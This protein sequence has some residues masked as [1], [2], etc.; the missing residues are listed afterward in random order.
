MVLMEPTLTWLLR[1]VCFRLVTLCCALRERW[2]GSDNDVNVR[3]SGE[4][5]SV[6][7]LFLDLCFWAS[8]ALTAAVLWIEPAS[9]S[10]YIE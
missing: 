8:C 7:L 1:S 5:L 3:M 10:A 9:V 4:S 6:A 2:L